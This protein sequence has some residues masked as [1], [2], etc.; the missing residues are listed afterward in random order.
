MT[1]TMDRK[2]KRRR[3]TP[4][5]M[6]RRPDAPG[7]GIDRL[8]KMTATAALPD[9]P[10]AIMWRDGT[11]KHGLLPDPRV[12]LCKAFNRD[13]QDLGTAYA[14]GHLEGERITIYEVV[15][16]DGEVVDSAA[17]R[18]A[19]ALY[20][21]GDIARDSLLIREVECVVIRREGGAK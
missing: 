15:H 2:T 20:I 4:G 7:T 17:T 1:K 10:F 13:Y 6:K 14:L 9:L 18:E 19:A 5:E 8:L 3:V 21:A 11:I 12:G 16:T